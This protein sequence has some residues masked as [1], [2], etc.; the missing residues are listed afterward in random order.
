MR[1][2]TWNIN[3]VR[4]RINSVKKVVKKL[5]PD[6]LCLQE[7]KCLKEDFPFKDFETMGFINTE[8]FGIKGYNGVCIASKHPINSVSKHIFCKKDD[9][10]HINIEFLYKNKKIIV[11]NFYVPA[12]GDEPDPKIND[13]FKHKLKFLDEAT[14]LFSNKKS[15]NNDLV[16]LVG[17]LNIAPHEMD[18]W[19]HQQLKNVVSHTEIEIK[20]LKNFLKSFQF[21]DAIRFSQGYEKKIYSWWSY[22][23][24]DW[25]KTNRGRRLDHIWVSQKMSNHLEKTFIEKNIRS[26]KRPSDH[27]PVV[28]DFK[29]N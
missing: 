3:S 16:V 6:I 27:V 25:K 10:R 12:G 9:A 18:V 24:K 19:S 26:W 8:A 13:K 29:F 28:A 23:A 2:V 7:T 5:N 4:L 11:H 20:K 1:V 14:K 15:I 22:R 21:E 17:D